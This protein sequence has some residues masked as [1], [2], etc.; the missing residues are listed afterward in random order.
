ME[1][2]QLMPDIKKCEHCGKRVE[3]WHGGGCDC[4]DAEEAKVVV[5]KRIYILCKHCGAPYKSKPGL[6][7]GCRV[8]R[9]KM[10]GFLLI[11]IGAAVVFVVLVYR[12]GITLFSGL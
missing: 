1:N 2:A 5:K 10:A 3:D 4:S 9:L 7:L 12:I 6:C 8:N 11:G